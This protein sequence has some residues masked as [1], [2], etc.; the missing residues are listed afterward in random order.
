MRTPDYI[1]IE[2]PRP[3]VY[4][5]YRGG[6]CLYVG[7]TI[8]GISARIHTHHVVSMLPG[9]EIRVWNTTEEELP[10]LEAK[11]V[12]ELK[13]KLNTRWAFRSK[14]GPHKKG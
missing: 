11:T 5:W 7:G 12:T 2:A 9:D 6:E 13:P 10:D 4:A 1:V 14:R 8:R 3:C